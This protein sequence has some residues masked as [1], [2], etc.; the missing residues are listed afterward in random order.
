MDSNDMTKSLPLV[1]R[2]R[3]K[4]VIT[5]KRL[6]TEALGE[7]NLNHLEAYARE[8]REVFGTRAHLKSH[9]EFGSEM[10]R[11]YIHVQE[12]FSKTKINPSDVNR[13][14]AI[15]Q[16]E[17]WCGRPLH[18]AERHALY[19]REGGGFI[20]IVDTMSKKIVDEQIEGYLDAVLYEY[21]PMDQDARIRLAEELLA[22][23]G[24]ALYPGP[25][26]KLAPMI[27]G[28]IEG[29]IKVLVKGLRQLGRTIRW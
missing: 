16:L 6:V 9:E 18:E 26:R 14:M 23:Y 4:P 25:H 7:E 21:V 1:P 19:V 3:A 24:E 2:D 11:W 17:R 22:L 10:F 29:H 27:A 8:C 15:S 5:T 28:D 13:P 20:G 12:W